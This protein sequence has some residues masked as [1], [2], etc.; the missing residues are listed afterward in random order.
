M[1]IWAGLGFLMWKGSK[2]SSLALLRKEDVRMLEIK[3][4]KITPLGPEEMREKEARVKSILLHCK[5]E[6]TAVS[7]CPQ[8]VHRGCLMSGF[9]S[10]KSASARLAI[11]VWNQVNTPR[12]VCARDTEKRGKSQKRKW[13]VE[14]KSLPEMLWSD[15]VALFL[16]SAAIKVDFAAY[17]LFWE[18][19]VWGGFD[20][21]RHGEKWGKPP[22]P[23][24]AQAGNVLDIPMCYW[25]RINMLCVCVCR[26]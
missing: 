15:G 9:C 22:C 18:L 26:L 7:C 6:N 12:N 14:S 16:L 21:C 13:L 24:Q 1:A 19:A 5:G 20:I 10:V 4:S 3:S 25:T 2:P 8:R 17:H 11:F 23:S